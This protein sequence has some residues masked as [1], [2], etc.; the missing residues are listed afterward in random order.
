MNY[1]PIKFPAA[2]MFVAMVRPRR[3][4]TFGGGN[5]DSARDVS[6]DDLALFR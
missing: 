1:S 3:L 4:F 5:I 6:C 2:L